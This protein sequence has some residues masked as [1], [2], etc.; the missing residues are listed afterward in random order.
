MSINIFFDNVFRINILGDIKTWVRPK[1]DSLATMNFLNFLML[2]F[3][4]WQRTSS[5][6]FIRICYI[7]M[8]IIFPATMY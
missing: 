1:N 3:V 8:L 4:G 7:Q 5:I 2:V 6:N